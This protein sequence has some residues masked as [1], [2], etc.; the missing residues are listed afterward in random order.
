MKFFDDIKWCIDRVWPKVC[1]GKYRSHH[2][3]FAFIDQSGSDGHC[4][5]VPVTHYRCCR[6]P[7]MEKE[8]SHNEP[9]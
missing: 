8:P 5:N 2:L 1:L 6:C 9:Y 7:Y 4:F 3:H